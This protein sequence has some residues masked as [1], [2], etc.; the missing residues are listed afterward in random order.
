MYHH[1]PLWLHHGPAKDGQNELIDTITT[2]NDMM[3]KFSENNTVEQLPLSVLSH[4]AL[5][6]M[7]VNFGR[8]L[9]LGAEDHS[10]EDKTLETYD[11]LNS[12]CKLR[13]GISHISIWAA[14]S[15]QLLSVSAASSPARPGREVSFTGTPSSQGLDHPHLLSSHPKLYYQLANIIDTSLANGKSDL[16]TNPL[17]LMT[18]PM[19]ISRQLEF[20]ADLQPAAATPINSSQPTFSSYATSPAPNMSP[21]SQSDYEM[22]QAVAMTT[23]KPIRRGNIWPEQLANGIVGAHQ[24]DGTLD[25]QF[26]VGS[27]IEEESEPSY[28]EKMVNTTVDGLIWRHIGLFG[29]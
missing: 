29:A 15:F 7:V 27:V 22:G 3:Q 12:Q 24:F 28:N 5:P 20:V 19:G 1:T 21:H 17:L 11:E 14:K 25:E 9:A 2:I 16:D 8:Q 23:E 10:A 13:F 26:A 6:Q 18:Y 4:T